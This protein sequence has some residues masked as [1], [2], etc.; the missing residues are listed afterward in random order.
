[1]MIRQVATGS[2]DFYRTSEEVRIAG[3][4]SQGNLLAQAMFA[5]V[6]LRGRRM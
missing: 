1:M 5:T 6:K 3:G 4:E 2:R